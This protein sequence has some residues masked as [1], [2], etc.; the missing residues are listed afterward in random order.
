MAMLD[1][2]IANLALE[3]VR[4]DLD[5]SLSGVQWVATGYLIAL[6]VSLPLTGWLGRR[7]GYGRLWAGSVLIFVLASILCAVSHDLALLI[8]SRCLQGL[9]AGLMVPAGQAILAATADRRQLGRLMGALGFAVALGPAL[10]PAFGGVL[11]DT[12]SWRWLFLINVPVGM[13]ALVGAKRLV[14]FGEGSSEAQIDTLGFALIGLG[15]PLLLYGAAEMGSGNVSML[16]AASSALG[17][18]LSALFVVHSVRTDEPLIDIG[19]LMRTGFSAPVITAGLTGAAMYGG[20]LLLPIFLQRSVGQTPTAAGFMLLAMGLGSA[21]V[22][23]VAGTLTDRF[24]P[25]RVSLAGGA[26]LTLTTAPFLASAPLVYGVLAVLLV[27]RGAGLALAQM[28]AITAA[29]NEVEK[30][31]T[32]DAATLINIAQRLGGAIGAITVVAVIEQVGHSASA[33]AYRVAFGM[34]VALA[35]GAL[36]AATRIAASHHDR[37]CL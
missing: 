37:D 24:G 27:A 2:T 32:G 17:A 33:T 9:A 18:S 25:K 36:F 23:P 14:A 16:T 11:I 13:A 7:F 31:E 30:T 22:L 12:T 4:T 15:L 10:G 3:T 8:A 19:L 29:Y 1:S 6:A 20:L 35:A 28:P 5:A 21:F 34:L 26:L